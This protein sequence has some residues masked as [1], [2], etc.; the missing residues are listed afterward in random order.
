M[1]SASD[2]V[3]RSR[4]RVL[5]A[6]CAPLAAWLALG[7]SAPLRA[8]P[9]AGSW[10]ILCGA[11]AGSTVDIVARRAAE[12]LGGRDGR[13]GRPVI[14][15]NRPG[16]AGHLAVNALKAASPDALTLMLAP[17]GLTTV[18]PHTYAKLGY[19]P[20]GDLQPVSLAAE[21]GMGLA[22]GPA[23]PANVGTLR[24]FID[25]MRRNPKHA[26]VASPGVGSLPHLLQAQFFRQADVEWQH[27][28]Y[29]GGPPALVDLIGG[30]IAALALPE[31]I[32]RQHKAAGRLRV[33]A[34]SGGQRSVFLPDVPN[35]VE[36]GYRDLVMQEWFAF[37]MAARAPATAVESAS[38]SIRD[39]LAKPELVAAYAEAG[40]VAASS[41]PAA[42]ATRIATERR[43]WEPIIR[44]LGIRAE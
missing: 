3:L 30:Q 16:A 18:H 25:W 4:R 17:G 41:T 34:T 19:D 43:H 23:V 6:G 12:H 29:S 36:Q 27:V 39:A 38:Q 9:A 33:L 35:F 37:F 14:V 5:C 26:N 42:L 2:L 20:I 40:I 10:R 44:T 11:P 31:G 15:D 1:A 22:I 8:Q 28:V 24:E 13:D 21:M 7:A 32:L